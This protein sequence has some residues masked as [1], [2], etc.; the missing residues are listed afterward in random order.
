VLWAFSSS[1]GE[2]FLDQWAGA[3]TLGVDEVG[4]AI[5]ASLAFAACWASLLCVQILTT[6]GLLLQDAG[7]LS[8]PGNDAQP[9]KDGDVVLV[10]MAT[11]GEDRGG[12]ADESSTGLWPGRGERRCFGENGLAYLL[13]PVAFLPLVTVVVLLVERR[14]E[15]GPGEMMMSCGREKR[16][17]PPYRRRWAAAYLFSLCALHGGAGTPSENLLVLV[18]LTRRHWSQVD[19]DPNRKALEDDLGQQ[20]EEQ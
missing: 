1:S 12:R 2:G 6:V 8:L 16:G 3:G 11:S 15:V 5:V 9:G 20:L 13:L 17:G 18:S 19:L 7:L 4:D 14:G 10:T